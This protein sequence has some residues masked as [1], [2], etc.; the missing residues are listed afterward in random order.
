MGTLWKY[1][2]SSNFRH[3]FTALSQS[4]IPNWSRNCH[5]KMQW[6]HFQQ[7]MRFWFEIINLE[8]QRHCNNAN[9]SCTIF[10]P[11]SF[12]RIS[13]LFFLFQLSDFHMAK[14]A[15]LKWRWETLEIGNLT[16]K[17][18]TKRSLTKRKEFS[19]YWSDDISKVVWF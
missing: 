7:W 9:R 17:D 12:C 2:S 3:N 16:L 15:Y 19:F 6:H 13:S 11:S 5:L 1:F 18:V 8:A 10:W 14:I 4:C